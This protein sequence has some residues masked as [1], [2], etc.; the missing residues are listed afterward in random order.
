M[1]RKDHIITYCLH[2]IYTLP[3]DEHWE[4]GKCTFYPKWEDVDINNHGC[5]CGTGVI[6][7]VWRENPPKRPCGHK[8]LDWTD[9]QTSKTVD[10]FG[11]T[12]VI[13]CKCGA[14]GRQEYWEGNR[15][16]VEWTLPE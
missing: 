6:A 3:D 16:K 12:R 9:V 7:E 2:C 14:V 10:S 15:G 11:F 4:T 13:K 8:K 1:P 5:G